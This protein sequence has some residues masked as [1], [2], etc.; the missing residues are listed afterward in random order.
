MHLVP[1]R[2]ADYADRL[3]S[4]RWLSRLVMSLAVVAMTAFVAVAGTSYVSAVNA[5][6]YASFGD[7]TSQWLRDHGAGGI[8]DSVETWYYTR[9]V[10]STTAADVKQFDRGAPASDA[11]LKLPALPKPV[12]SA[13]PPRWQPGRPAATGRPALYTSSFEPDRAHPSVIAGVA[14]IDSDAVKLHLMTGTAQPRSVANRSIARVPTGDI[15][16]LVAVFNSGFRFGDIAGGV[17]AFGHELK[18]LHVGS[19]TAVIDDHGRLTVGQWGRDVSWSS[20]LVSARQNLALLV[21][22]G[23][24]QPQLRGRGY[25][26][27]TG[28]E[29]QYTWRSGLGVDRN[30]N[31]VYVAGNQLDVAALATALVDAGAVRAMQLDIHPGMTTFVTYRVDGGR[32]TASKLLTWQPGPLG[33]YLTPDRRD[34]FYVTTG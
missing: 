14:I 34:F 31:V 25:W 29:K 9:H 19:A 33:R 10:P 2:L 24:A 13:T 26:G 21:D 4:V 23:R 28:L 5:P 7:K 32:P 20:H 12:G 17:Y 6:G 8:V 1:Q 3:G 15:A 11:L 16:S 18:P 22:A 27:G 30:G